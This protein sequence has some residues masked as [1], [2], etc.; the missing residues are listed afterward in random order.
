MRMAMA[1]SFFCCSPR[2]SLFCE[3][4]VANPLEPGTSLA[5]SIFDLAMFTAE[6]ALH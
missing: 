4:L 6:N 2:I 3:G 5:T 1:L